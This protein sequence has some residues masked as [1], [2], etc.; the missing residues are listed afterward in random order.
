MLRT[1]LI[2][3]LSLLAS[4][5]AT[6]SPAAADA[7]AQRPNIVVMLVDDMGWSDIGC[8]G[9]E[10]ATP[11]LDALA[12]DG[13]RFTQFYN[14][15]RC[16]PSRAALLTGLYSHQAGMGWLD[17]K[18]EPKSKGFHGRL[19][20]RCVTIAE[21]LREAGYFTAMTGKWHLG[22]QNGT[23][24]WTRGFD[25][26]LNSRYGEVYFPHESDRP[27]TKF[28]YLN[29]RELP[30]DS[31]EIGRDWYSTDLFVDWGL[32]FIDEAQA[33]KKPFFLY[34]AQG[35]V[36]F[37][38]RAPAETI[39]RHRGKYL[40]GWD[41]LRAQRHA[42]QIEMGLVDAAWPLAPRPSE[43]PAWSTRTDEQKDRFD[44]MMAVYA[45]MVERIDRS[46][47]T[48]VD[49]LQARGMLD[50]TLI[51]FL[52]DNGGNA[53]GGP[54]GVTR[55]TGPIGGPDSYVWLGMNWATACNTPL[56]RYKH[57]THE[58]GIS[59]P[60]VVHWPAGIPAER[61]GKLEKQPAHLIDI[62]ATAVDLA[63]AKY[64]TEFGGNQILPME[65]VTLRPALAGQALARIQPI[66][67]EHEGNKAVRDGRW[68]L[69]QKWREPWELYDIEADR[70]EQNNLIA[71]Q[72]EI[73]KRL[74]TA[75][76]AWAARA[77]VDDWPGPDHTAWGADLKPD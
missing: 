76:N 19:L 12:A 63:G 45:A 52:S 21:V 34:V 55:G 40:Q 70:T 69:V 1:P 27:G 14:T 4:A 10:I 3:A 30:K 36:H 60:L 68:K 31:P 61:R 38:L 43:S 35:A 18:V 47:G 28:L 64:P 37:P 42:R 66:F 50:N 71:A 72:P 65:G 67:W 5:L 59:S 44:Q 62:M 48:L 2:V 77:F 33:A 53:E 20:P 13:L 74:E 15:P 16:S 11:R 49:G 6:I 7:P 41:L 22:Q 9:S 39:A 54:P 25:R 46:M 75:W 26:S 32:K 8:Y 23:P 17:N 56:R 73:A 51:L 58:G 24:P 29:G 57:F